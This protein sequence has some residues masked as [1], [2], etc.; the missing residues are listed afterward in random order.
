M[1]CKKCTCIIQDLLRDPDKEFSKTY[2]NYHAGISSSNVK[3]GGCEMCK[4][5]VPPRYRSLSTIHEFT[6]KDHKVEVRKLNTKIM[7]QDT[8]RYLWPP[9]RAN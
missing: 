7:D 8:L 9:L 2:Y 3:A 1:L 4:V 5:L 6:E